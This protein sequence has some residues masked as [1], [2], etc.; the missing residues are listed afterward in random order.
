M[1]GEQDNSIEFRFEDLEFFSGDEV[2]DLIDDEQD[3]G[4]SKEKSETT[5]SNEGST[6][7]S[8]QP[9]GVETQA[10]QTVENNKL[11]QKGGE[12]EIEDTTEGV[13]SERVSGSTDEE[14]ADSQ[15]SPQVYSAL[16]TVL[17]E[18][19]VLSSVD[20][21]SLEKVQDIDGLID[22]IREQIQAEEFKDLSEQQKTVLNDM[23]AGVEPST[24]EKF[25]N[26][27][28]KLDRINDDLIQSEKQ[29]RFDLIYEDYLSKGFSADK[30]EKYARRSFELKE[31]LEDAKEAKD[32]LKRAVK[33]QYDKAKEKELEKVNAE[34][35]AKQDQQDKLK[36]QILKSPE[37][38]E[39]AEVSEQLRH[40]VYDA[41]SRI[42]SSN[43]EDG[44]PENALQQYQRENPIDYNHKL[45][46]LFKVTNGFKDL[47]YFGRRKTTN[48]VK[49]L[50][51]A[52]RQSSH[53]RG[54]GNPSFND[55][56]QSRI[57]DIGDLV[58]PE[59]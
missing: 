43:P 10:A 30:A 51:S 39:G 19:G 46:Y 15:S 32:S 4:D 37:V 45:Y 8:S 24:A 40:E 9:E 20:E 16:T 26:A 29:I 13:T 48:S 11:A 6:V 59:D 33:G 54:G 5:T 56:I 3:K 50:E 47:K 18:K 58:L 1:A 42:V 44:T 27:M 53:V 38:F 36:Q 2:Q 49:E 57:L 7:N 22:V 55:D 52:L 34:K 28:D 14:G 17:R 41:M 25:K 21:S 35:R 23:R 31:D 12:E